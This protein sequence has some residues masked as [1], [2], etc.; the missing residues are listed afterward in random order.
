MQSF[1]PLLYNINTNHNHG[2]KMINIDLHNPEFYYNELTKEITDIIW[3]NLEQGI[4][5]DEGNIDWPYEARILEGNDTINWHF[6]VARDPDAKYTHDLWA[7]AGPDDCYMPAVGFSV[8]LP[9]GKHIKKHQMSYAELFGT[10]AHE[11]H[12]IAQNTEENNV[13]V[14]PLFNEEVKEEDLDDAVM[15]YYLS[16]VEIGAFHIGFRAQC[17]ISGEDL[18]EA[19][20]KYLS[21][22]DLTGDQKLKI[23]TAWLNPTFDIVKHNIENPC[24]DYDSEEDVE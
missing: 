9:K 13:K 11:L 22:Q 3:S 20:Y 21:H 4:K 17:A 15:D 2:V 1:K 7:C 5:S 24:T 10:V 18:E 14:Y 12:H 6:N 16:A 8:V 19:M 23:V